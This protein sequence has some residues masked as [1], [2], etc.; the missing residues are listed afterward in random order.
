MRRHAGTVAAL[1]GISLLGPVV[2]GLLV[3]PEGAVGQDKGKVVVQI[4]GGDWADANFEAY[5]APFEKETGIK[6]VAVR[7]WMSIAKLKLMVESKKV[8]LDVADI[9]RLH[10]LSAVKANYLEKIDYSIYKKAEL[11]KIDD[12]SKQPYGVGAA[13]FSYIMAFDN[14][15]FPPGKRPTTWAE[16]WDAKKFPGPR[17]L[18]A[19]VYGTGAYEEALLADGVPMD[20]L[21]PMDVDRAFKSLDKIRP[22]VTTWWKEGAEGQQL[23]ADKVVTIG[24]VFNG[25]IGNL[26]KKG[27]PLDIE[28]N[29]GKL[30]L[31]YWVIPNGAPNPQNAQKFIEFATRANRQGAFSELI[32]YGP[33]NAAAFEYIKPETAKQLPTYPANLKKQ[34]HRNEDWYAE[35]GP[36]GR[37]NLELIIERWN[38]WTVQ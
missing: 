19:G 16:F 3:A 28:W 14:Q 2:V 7:D 9:P 24:D 10:Y 5:V 4:G 35:I 12:L 26:Q 29:Q 25:R 36:G 22:S 18:R 30:Q 21:Y 38:R 6:V 11:N 34:F 8:E 1:A 17:T 15:K 23:F 13:Y 33:T 32:P 37:S 20:K 31:D 27:M